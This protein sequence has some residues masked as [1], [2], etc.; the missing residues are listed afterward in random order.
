MNLKCRI[1]VQSGSRF[2]W[3]DAVVVRK[4]DES[5][6]FV[7]E[8]ECDSCYYVSAEEIFVNLG[9]VKRLLDSQI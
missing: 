6:Y 9:D 3:V 5:R 8:V 4:I 7:R 1:K 2:I